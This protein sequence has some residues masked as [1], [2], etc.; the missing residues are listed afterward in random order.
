MQKIAKQFDDTNVTITR[1]RD[2]E[3]K[4]ELKIDEETLHDEEEAI[5]ESAAE[6]SPE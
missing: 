6:V 2:T 1:E 3:W 4:N 5:A